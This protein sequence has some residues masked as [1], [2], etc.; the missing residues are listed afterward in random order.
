MC[1]K[2]PIS[3]AASPASS[4]RS[5]QLYFQ[6]WG[7]QSD[8][9]AR[10]AAKNHKNGVDNPYAQMRKDLGYD[11]CRAESEKNPLRRRAAQAHRL[12]ARLRRR[13]RACARRRRNRAAAAQGRRVPRRAARAGLSCRCRAATCSSSK[14]A[15][16][17]WQRA[18]AQAGVALDDLSF[19]EVHDCFTI[20]E[21]MEYEAMG[22][23]PQGPGRARDREGVDER[24][25]AAGQS[26]R[27][28]QS[29]G[30]SDRR[31]RRVDAC[32]RLDAAHRQAGDMQIKTPSSAAFSTWAAP[33]SPITCSILE[34]LR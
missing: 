18:L 16:L 28:A 12:L 11:F 19:A 13:R 21:L 1:A 2:R 14:A 5:P 6:R 23:A 8:A 33:P 32:D 10:I 7:D 22:L 9:L 30:P 17:A 3:T 29:Q 31:H 34:R 25:Q 15:A 20:A 24:R 27:R 4:A 26:V